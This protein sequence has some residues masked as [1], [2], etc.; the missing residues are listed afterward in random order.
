MGLTFEWD[1]GKA[2]LN[3]QKHGVSFDEATT[4]FRDT[5]SLTIDDPLHSDE[6]DRLIII[7]TSN[8]ARLLVVVHVDRETTIRSISARRATRRERE[9]YERAST[10]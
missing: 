6:E 8:R 3:L 4:V 2:R 10:A 1:E 5:F 9:M 7:G